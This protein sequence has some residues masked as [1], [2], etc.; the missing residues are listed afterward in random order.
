MGSKIKVAILQADLGASLTEQSFPAELAQKK[1]KLPVLLYK[2]FGRFVQMLEDG[3]QW[4]NFLVCITVPV[5]PCNGIT[6]PDSGN[7]ELLVIKQVGKK[8]CTH[9]DNISD[10]SQGFCSICMQSYN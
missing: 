5:S 10:S 4:L 7:T 1:K 3:L 6:Y 2:I 9:M 8:I